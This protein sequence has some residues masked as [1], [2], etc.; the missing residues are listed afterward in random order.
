MVLLNQRTYWETSPIKGTI[1]TLGAGNASDAQS[2]TSVQL[3]TMRFND[4]KTF[5]E[6]RLTGASQIE[7]SS[8][9]NTDNKKDGEDSIETKITSPDIV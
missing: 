9:D 8:A 6:A 7:S 1:S 2:S 3:S 5:M 4:S